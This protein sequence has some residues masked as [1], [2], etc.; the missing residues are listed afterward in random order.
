MT[1]SPPAER[2][3]D[4]TKVTAFKLQID[5]AKLPDMEAAGMKPGA[6]REMLTAML[7]RDGI[8]YS[9]ADFGN[10]V[11]AV[12]GDDDVL[13]RAIKAA[14][15][16]DTGSLSKALVAAG[17]DTVC[18]MRMDFRAVMRWASGLMK[19]AG[20]ENGPKMDV[21]AGDPVVVTMVANAGSNRLRGRL[22]LDVG[23]DG[24]AV[25][26][27]DAKV[28]WARNRFTTQVLTWMPIRSLLQLVLAAP[29]AC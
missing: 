26:S 6:N 12:L 16:A 20:G 3:V 25:Q 17:P 22:S 9:I 19:S 7:G 24:E 4:G 5:A 21:A 14:K 10:R 18:F 15:A 11:M 27:R 8:S 28:R 29:I 1:F 13:K 2:T 23:T